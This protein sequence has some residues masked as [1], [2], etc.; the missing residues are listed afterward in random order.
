MKLRLCLL[1]ATL[2]CLTASVRA[3]SQTY[4]TYNS[5][6]DF[7]TYF[8]MPTSGDCSQW[9]Q[10]FG[11]SEGSFILDNGP[12]G[13]YTLEP[14][15]TYLDDYGAIASGYYHVQGYHYLDASGFAGVQFSW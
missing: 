14:G 4:I 15:F 1:L 7:D 6:D 12:L 9:A 2:A 10:Y 3:Q 13:N 8:E 11:G 5:S